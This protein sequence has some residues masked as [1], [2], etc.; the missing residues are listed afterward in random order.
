MAGVLAFSAGGSGT[1]SGY[2]VA[3]DN[4][5]NVN[6][7]NSKLAHFNFISLSLF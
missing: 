4:K 7:P 3:K 5:G 6:I 1:A 2:G